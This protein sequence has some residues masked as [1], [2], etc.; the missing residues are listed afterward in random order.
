MEVPGP[1]MLIDDIQSSSALTLSTGSSQEEM[2]HQ[3]QMEAQRH[4]FARG[5]IQA[6]LQDPVNFVWWRPYLLRKA[7]SIATPKLSSFCIFLSLQDLSVSPFSM[8]WSGA[9]K[10][11]VDASLI[12]GL[13][14][15]SVYHLSMIFG[16]AQLPTR[17]SGPPGHQDHQ[18][19]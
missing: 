12:S 9:N 14:T 19:V 16:N 7:E 5:L 4:P 2:H 10:L 18:S 13:H 1:D 15:F 8:V 11:A 3:L 17:S 6:F